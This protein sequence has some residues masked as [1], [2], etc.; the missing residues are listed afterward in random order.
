MRVPSRFARP[1]SPPLRFLAGAVSCP[2]RGGGRHLQ[3]TVSAPKPR[4]PDAFAETRRASDFLAPRPAFGLLQ[5]LEGGT[6]G[7]WQV[8]TPLQRETRANCGPA[9]GMLCWRR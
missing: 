7:V 1:P 5:E 9:G 3:K 2:T 6:R 4:F 8:L